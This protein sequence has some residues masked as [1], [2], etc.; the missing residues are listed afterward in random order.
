MDGTLT[1]PLAVGFVFSQAI[2]KTEMPKGRLDLSQ[3]IQGG[4]TA[5]MIVANNNQPKLVRLL[6]E[7]HSYPHKR[8]NRH[9]KPVA[10]RGLGVGVR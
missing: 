1:L 9:P 5:L 4:K 8:P 2:L 10:G 7:A 3:P 6:L